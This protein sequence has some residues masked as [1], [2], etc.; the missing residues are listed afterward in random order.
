M[1]RQARGQQLRFIALVTSLL[2]WA[3][4]GF[5]QNSEQVP[6]DVLERILRDVRETIIADFVPKNRA[7]G[8]SSVAISH[9]GSFVGITTGIRPSFSALSTA[10]GGSGHVAA[11][12]DGSLL[13]RT[14]SYTSVSSTNFLSDDTVLILRADTGMPTTFRFDGVSAWSEI[15]SPIPANRLRSRPGSWSVNWTNQSGRLLKTKLSPPED[16]TYRRDLYTPRANLD[17]LVQVVA[18]NDGVLL[19]GSEFGERMQVSLFG[20]NPPLTAD[21]PETVNRL[22]FQN[23]NF[24][25]DPVGDPVLWTTGLM[26]R[27]RDGKFESVPTLTYGRALVDNSTG[28][29]HGRY[30]P[31]ELTLE[32]TLPAPLASRLRQLFRY[33][34]RQGWVVKDVVINTASGRAVAILAGAGEEDRALSFVDGGKD[35]QF[36]RC[37]TAPDRGASP[38]SLADRLGRPEFSWRLRNLGSSGR[39]LP[40]WEV[41]ARP[42]YVGTLVRFR[43]GPNASIRDET[44]SGLELRLL[45]EG[46][47]IINPDYSG[48]AHTSLE[49]ANR[50]RAGFEAALTEDVARISHHYRL[51]SD[52]RPLVV[53]GESYGSLPA[54][55]L[56]RHLSDRVDATLLFVPFGSRAKLPTTLT[57][58]DRIA[59]EGLLGTA[60]HLGF[61]A[62]RQWTG[63]EVDAYQARL[64]VFLGSLCSQPRVMVFLGSF[65]TITPPESWLQGCRAGIPHVIEP[66]GGH[67]I[68]QDTANMAAQFISSNVSARHER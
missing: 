20:E 67:F 4:P 64:D 62:P 37:D 11:W 68:S 31:T 6:S 17:G 59:V 3:S 33:A 66:Y 58:P 7:C 51:R 24:S 25:R 44:L 14:L 19:I 61:G 65:D 28:V 45:S 35:L 10:M 36:M 26:L 55:A 23:L 18:S 52:S 15:A 21:L 41:Q 43:G 34:N 13:T 56:S 22:A 16:Q 32:P 12:P 48:A 30:G 57:E 38:V 54:A 39:V 42:D 8:A 60:Q 40:A 29:V 53:T 50:L 49:V 63:P 46:W 9:S 47:R 27:L 5:G 1:L 2:F